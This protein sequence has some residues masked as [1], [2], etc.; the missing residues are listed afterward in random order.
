MNVGH[1]PQT[2]TPKSLQKNCYP[3]CKSP[4]HDFGGC[5]RWVKMCQDISSSTNG[6]DCWPGLP[7]SLSSAQMVWTA[8]NQYS[9]LFGHV[10]PKTNHYPL[11]IQCTNG[12]GC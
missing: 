11:T 10:Y 6:L 12:V 9:L 2:S 7:Q 1:I 4:S 8:E 5:R 3:G